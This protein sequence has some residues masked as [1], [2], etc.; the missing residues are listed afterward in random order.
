MDE[1]LRDGLDAGQQPEQLAAALV[2][3]SRRTRIVRYLEVGVYTAWSTC[4]IAAFLSRAHSRRDEPFSGHAVDITTRHMHPNMR[5]LFTHL[6]GEP[7]STGLR[8]AM[9]AC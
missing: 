5:V 3:V 6:N 4:T 1:P 7:S 2:A 8:R 9:V